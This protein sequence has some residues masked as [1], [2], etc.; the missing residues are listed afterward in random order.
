MAVVVLENVS[1]RYPS[2]E[3]WSPA[4][5][6]L[7]L[8][9]E[10]GVIQGIIGF[11][12]AGKSTLLRCVSRL[13]RPD[14][15]RVLID[16]ADLAT[17]DGAALRSA[18][19]KLGVVFQQFHLMRSRTVAGNVALPL[20]VGGDAAPA[21]AMRVR[22]LLAWVG[23]DEKADAYPA[24]LSGGQRQRVAI[25]RALASRPSVLLTDEPTSALD[26]ETT[27]SVLEL[28]RRV[29]DQLGV[30]ILLITHELDA[31]RAVCDRVAVLD[32]GR[33]AEEGPVHAVLTR[34]ESRATERLLGRDQHLANLAAQL[35]DRAAHVGAVF[36]E[37]QFFGAAGANGTGAD[38]T[39]H[40]LFDVARRSE[41][42]ISVLHAQIA[43]MNRAGF[44]SMLVELTGA[45]AAIAAAQR[46][47]LARGTQVVEVDP[48]KDTGTETEKKP[49]G[50]RG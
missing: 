9:V 34:P 47:L 2:R 36:L 30:T 38:A 18:R 43:N 25:A 33:I 50:V 3:G 39:D 41:A 32:R 5:V 27:A 28:L 6:D 49:G 12:G 14:A 22:E 46:E 8:S 24:Q 19:R 31:V 48:W 35:G 15:G 44:G 23:L 40:V 7:N 20:E 21:I 11:S 4:L 45:P 13:E 42:T 17:L 37:V 26:P 10:R 16:G 1:K 29:R